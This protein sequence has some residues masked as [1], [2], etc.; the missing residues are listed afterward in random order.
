MQLHHKMGSSTVVLCSCSIMG[1]STVVLC[2]CSIMGSSTVV[3]CSCL[4]CAVL[5]VLVKSKCKTN[6]WVLFRNTCNWLQGYNRVS[7]LLTVPRNCTGVC[8]IMYTLCAQ[9][10]PLS[11]LW[12]ESVLTQTITAQTATPPTPALVR[13]D[14]VSGPSLVPGTG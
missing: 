13:E 1:S 9:A 7:V 8:N 4:L 3:L 6:F 11:W 10:E 2:S 14:I 12:Q 5:R